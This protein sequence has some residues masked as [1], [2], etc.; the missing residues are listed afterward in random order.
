MNFKLY[1]KVN[2]NLSYSSQM[3]NFCF[4]ILAAI[5]R[6]IDKHALFTNEFCKKG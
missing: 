2:R 6:C 3:N 5:A 1:E 4:E